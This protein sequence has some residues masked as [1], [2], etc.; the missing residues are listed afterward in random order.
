MNPIDWITGNDTGV[1]SKV[2][3]SVMMG[4][5]PKTVDVPHDPADFGRCHRL[6]GLFPEWRNR[7]EEVSAKFPK[8]GPMVREWETMEYL[9]E[10]DVSTGRC[11]D[12]YDFMQ[13]LMEECYVADGW[14]KTGPGSWRKNGSQ[15]LNIS[16]RAK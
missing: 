10:K 7:I 11:G 8:W 9:Y 6:F 15:H 3:W 14:K 2:I 13:K 5:S 16:V 12:L 4:S 1:S